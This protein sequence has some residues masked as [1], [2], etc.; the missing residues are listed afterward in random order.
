MPDE[1]TTTTE[2]PA[3]APTE[4]P[5]PAAD[6]GSPL[7]DTGALNRLAAEADKL[8]ATPEG[9]A[10]APAATPAPVEPIATPAEAAEAINDARDHGATEEQLQ[11]LAKQL[12]YV[13]DDRKIYSKE[14]V[15]FREHQRKQRAAL[16]EDKRRAL[17]E[18]EQARVQTKGDID[19]VNQIIADFQAGN[20]DQF[21][22]HLDPTFK[23]WDDLQRAVV[24]RVADPHYK[25]LQDLKQQL[26]AKE[27]REE[28]ERAEWRR[29]QQVAQVAENTRRYHA[30]LSQQMAQ[31]QDPLCAALSDDPRFVA[32]I[33][34]VQNEHWDEETRTTI[35]PEQAIKIVQRGMQRSIAD[36]MGEFYKKLSKVFGAAAPAV[37]AAV[38]NAAGIQAPPAAGAPAV[39]ETPAPP[40]SPKNKTQ[41]VKGPAVEPAAAANHEDWSTFKKYAL[42]KL[43][44]AAE[45]DKP[46]P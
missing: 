43:K 26:A 21:A 40:K 12:G 1:P 16:D 46:A 17:A 29:Q 32:A 42:E 33:A 14:R 19:R 10:S 8:K 5:A 23:N 18:I 3:A 20:W 35:R 39:A 2:T 11:N 31:S 22:T 28:Q 13:I 37:A 7:D 38:T 41:V 25:E 45:A 44:V 24:A 15:D 4:T 34:A 9:G 27:K 30:R 36:D 6:A